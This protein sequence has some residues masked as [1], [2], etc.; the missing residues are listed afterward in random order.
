MG[1]CPKRFSKPEAMY[2]RATTSALSK[3]KSSIQSINANTQLPFDH[4][5]T[6]SQSTKLYALPNEFY[7]YQQFTF[8]FGL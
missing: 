6:K 3:F 4:K 1:T 8:L 5:L 2:R 7:R